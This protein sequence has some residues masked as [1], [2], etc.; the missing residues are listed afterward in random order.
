M[1]ATVD[2]AIEAIVLADL[3]KANADMPEGDEDYG[4]YFPED[5][6]LDTWLK[7][8]QH[9]T[10]PEPGAYN[11]QDPQLVQHDWGVLNARYNYYA[12]LHTDKTS[13]NRIPL[14]DNA[15]NWDSLL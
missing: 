11:D 13:D 2:E 5:Y 3:G 7:Y 8:R 14:P 9:G 12:A 10:L 4:F 1:Q 6:V 15:P